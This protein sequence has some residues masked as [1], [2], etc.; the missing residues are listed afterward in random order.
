MWTVMRAP[1][2]RDRLLGNL[3]Q[4]LLPWLQQVADERLI[5]VGVGTSPEVT[6]RA[7]RGDRDRD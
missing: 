4:H 2:L 3:D 7:A 1:F 5:A 6:A